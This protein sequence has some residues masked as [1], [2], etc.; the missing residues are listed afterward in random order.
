[1]FK[2]N[3]IIYTCIIHQAIN[4]AAFAIISSTAALHFVV[5][6]VNLRIPERLSHQSFLHL[7]GVFIIIIISAYN[8]GNAFSVTSTLQFLPMPFAPPV[9]IITFR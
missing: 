7:N 5:G 1:M 4:P 3:A 9:T 8:N 6:S 2:T